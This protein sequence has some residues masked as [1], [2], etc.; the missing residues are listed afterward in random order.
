VRWKY[1]ADGDGRVAPGEYT[2]SPEGFARLDADGDGF[3]SS[4]DFAERW[5]GRPRVAGAFQYGIGGPEVGDPAPEFAL[6]TTDG[7]TLSLA[8]LRAAK[9]VVLVFGSFT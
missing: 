4:D 6:P 9:P 7:R 8:E 3:V 1:D 5:E 2:R